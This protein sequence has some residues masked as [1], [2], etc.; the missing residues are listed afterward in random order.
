MWRELEKKSVCASATDKGTK[1]S[2]QLWWPVCSSPAAKTGGSLESFF[3]VWVIVASLG[4]GH[5][6]CK[7][8]WKAA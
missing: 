6:R 1:A 2:E 8:N 7:G 5:R 4:V 3:I